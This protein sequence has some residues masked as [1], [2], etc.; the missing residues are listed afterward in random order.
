MIEEKQNVLFISGVYQIMMLIEFH[1][2]DMKVRTLRAN[3]D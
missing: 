1:M 2:P 3:E